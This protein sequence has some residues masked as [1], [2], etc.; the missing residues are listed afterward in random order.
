MIDWT[1]E[2]PHRLYGVLADWRETEKDLCLPAQEGTDERRRLCEEAGLDSY[3]D[4]EEEIL[5]VEQMRSLFSVV[6]DDWLVLFATDLDE[7]EASK[8]IFPGDEVLQCLAAVGRNY[9]G[10]EY[11]AA[12]EGAEVLAFIPL[13]GGLALLAQWWDEDGCE[14]T[15]DDVAKSLVWRDRQ[16]QREDAERQ[17]KLEAQQQ[18]AAEKQLAQEQAEDKKELLSLLDWVLGLA[19]LLVSFVGWGKAAYSL[20]VSFPGTLLGLCLVV[21]SWTGI[22][23]LCRKHK[24]CF[25]SS[26]S[27]A[28]L[29]FISLWTWLVEVYVK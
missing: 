24:W 15:A 16:K 14:V 18:A 20:G 4:L 12:H 27:A 17:A 9:E 1:C 22:S 5:R 11:R 2:V 29:I 21:A 26:G 10:I 19:L 3:F 6:S 28:L 8:A 13:F 23:T 7:V 25:I